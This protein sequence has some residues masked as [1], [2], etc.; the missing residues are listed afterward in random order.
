MSTI[1]VHHGVQKD[2]TNR[3][4]RKLG[5]SRHRSTHEKKR[6]RRVYTPNDNISTLKTRKLS[7]EYNFKNIYEPPNPQWSDDDHEAKLRICGV[8]HF[9]ECFACEGAN[10]G[11]GIKSG[12]HVYE[13]V[14]YRKVT[15][16]YGVS[17]KWNTLPV[18]SSCNKGYK[19]IKLVD[20][21]K[22]DAG[23]HD[24]PL[25]LVKSSK[26]RRV[27]KVIQTWK[28]YVA[29]RGAILH[30]KLNDRQKAVME[31]VQRDYQNLLTR[32]QQINE[33]EIA[34]QRTK[35]AGI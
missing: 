11:K 6:I 22:L 5:S 16:E 3:K 28:E 12:D 13:Q 32:I 23:L 15:G 25:H 1:T 27:V 20:G 24:I 9:K 34:K 14:G 21:R 8:R 31:G 30:F 26:D 4:K 10:N 35:Y 29:K 19:K 18:C 17:H 33:D 2:N 7:I